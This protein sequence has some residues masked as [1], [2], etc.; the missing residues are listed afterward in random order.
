MFQF[1]DAA[2]GFEPAGEVSQF[3][4][5]AGLTH[6]L[7]QSVGASV[8][9]P[10]FLLVGQIAA[11]ELPRAVPFQVQEGGQGQFGPAFRALEALELVLVETQR[12]FERFEEELV[13]AGA[14]GW[15]RESWSLDIRL[16]ESQDRLGVRS[17]DLQSRAA[18]V[19]FDSAA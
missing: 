19:P 15:L 6:R 12:R 13:L 2:W 4:L 14:S 7:A 9:P 11:G 16:R 3:V 5:L 10:E 8:S 1:A 17:V 18:A